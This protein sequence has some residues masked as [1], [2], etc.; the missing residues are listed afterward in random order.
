MGQWPAEII[1]ILWT[2]LLYGLKILKLI[3]R[4]A[5]IL[6]GENTVRDE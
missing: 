5:S 4:L 3:T 2:L 1:N 6:N